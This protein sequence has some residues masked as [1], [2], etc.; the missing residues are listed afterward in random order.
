MIITRSPLRI[1]FAGG[2]TDL[3]GFYKPYGPGAVVSTSIDRYVYVSVNEKFDKRVSLRY[4]VHEHVD[5]VVDLKHALVREI[6]LAY[7]VED[8]IEIV[9]A[10][11]VPAQGSGLGASSALGV[12]LCLALEHFTGRTLD[13]NDMR[14]A[15]RSVSAHGHEKG[16]KVFLAETAAS[17]EIEKVGS[18]IGKQDHYASALGGMNYMEFREEG[19]TFQA[20]EPNAFMRELEEQ[21]MLFYLN[22]E[23]DYKGGS[24]VQ[25]ILKD[26]NSEIEAKK[27]IYVLQRDNAQRLRE[28]I[29]YQ[30]IERF[31]DHV[32]ENWRLKKS[33]HPEISN[34]T[35]D[36]FMERAFKAGASAGKVCG[37]GG[38]GFVY[39]MVQPDMQKIVRKELGD[40][41]QELK[42]KFDNKGVQIIF[43]ERS[44]C[45]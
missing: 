18:P 7:G 1:S 3:P 29:D 39:L 11:E 10:S 35:I 14:I 28:H 8:N 36:L 31:M 16:W 27:A 22:L 42:F 15:S 23:H 32:N 44:E 17:I 19:A 9:I 25:K 43:S 6:L 13:K 26:Q 20:F 40:E 33:L 30:V 38:G 21:S 37:A 24:F 45:I 2:G 12:A 4:R 34:P 41:F 5:R